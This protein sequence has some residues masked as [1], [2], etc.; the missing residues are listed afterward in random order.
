MLYL[1]MESTTCLAVVC[2]IVVRLILLDQSSHLVS[3]HFILN[4][5]QIGNGKIIYVVTQL[6]LGIY[7]VAIG[8]SHIVHLVTKAND[9][10]ILSICP[11]SCHAHPYRDALLRFGILPMPY[12]HFARATHTGGDVT[13][14]TV[15]MCTLIQV[16]EIHIDLIPGNLLVE[17]G[18]EMHQ[19]LTEFLQ[20]MNPHFC[21]RKSMHPGNDADT[22]V[23]VV[24]R[25]HRTGN[26]LA[27]LT[28]PLYTTLT[29][30][31]P[32]AFK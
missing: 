7:L 10:Q 23:V 3:A 25:L 12:H 11:G 18:M 14:F 1:S 20:T 29:G 24:G 27:E 8:Y 9:A 32:E 6:Q 26:F 31:F 17:L 4:G 19:R 15:A 22:F 2:K 5:Y 21:R 16:H 28:V 30:R 13:K